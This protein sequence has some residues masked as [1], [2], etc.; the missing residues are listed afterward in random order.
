MGTPLGMEWGGYG[1]EWIWDDIGNVSEQMEE[2]V[3]ISVDA[4]QR[5]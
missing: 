2:K 5:R 3:E 4:E 1:V